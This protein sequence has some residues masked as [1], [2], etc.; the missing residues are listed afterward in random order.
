MFRSTYF[1]AL[2]L[3]IPRIDFMSALF[4]HRKPLFPDDVEYKPSR[5]IEIISIAAA[6]RCGA[7]SSSIYDLPRNIASL[8]HILSY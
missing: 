4:S 3:M 6:S 1:K 5:P 2:T 7:K 8:V